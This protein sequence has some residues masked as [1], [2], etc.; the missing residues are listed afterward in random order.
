MECRTSQY[1]TFEKGIFDELFKC[2]MD[3]MCHVQEKGVI[4][5]NLNSKYINKSSAYELLQI[6]IELMKDGRCPEYFNFILDYE[7]L[8]RVYNIKDFSDYKLAELTLM[9]RLISYL[10]TL[11]IE[12]FD[13]LMWSLCSIATSNELLIKLKNIFG[14]DLN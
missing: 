6:A 5:L 8:K 10:Q 11:D 7:L 1:I 9:K 2:I 14:F 3:L 13:E 12:K 4:E